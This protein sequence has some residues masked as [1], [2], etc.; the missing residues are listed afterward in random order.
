MVH[1]KMK[2]K[3]GLKFFTSIFF[4]Q[5]KIIKETHHFEDIGDLIQKQKSRKVG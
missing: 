3:I 1:A 2:K 4:M 5:A